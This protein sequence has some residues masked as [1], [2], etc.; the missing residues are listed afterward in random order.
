MA[1]IK[2]IAEKAG[3]SPATVSRVLNYDKSL[4][5]SDETRKKVFEIAEELDYKTVRERK[6]E[7]EVGKRIKVG[8]INWYSEKEELGDP[9]YLSI[10]LGAEKECYNKNVDIVK[11]FKQDDRYGINQ[12]DDLD[13]IIAIGKFSEDDIDTFLSYS[14]NI[15]FVDS[16]PNEKKFDSVVIDFKKAVLEVLKYLIKLGHNQI[17]YIGGREYVGNN[18]RLVEDEREETYISFMKEKGLFNPNNIYIGRFTAEDGY[19]LMKEALQKEE[20]PT[21]FFIAND[22]M[23]TG[24]IRALYEANLKVPD[25]IS[26]IGFNDNATSKFLVPPLSTVKVYTEFMGATAVNLLLE[27]INDNREI[28][29]KVI[30]PSELIIRES[31]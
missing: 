28:S 23:A 24:A 7:R 13:G 19:K 8:L 16:S 1:T 30:I 17:G 25:D 21:A 26:I 3:V 2:D 9:Y 5:V 10:R 4:S 12:F 20:V 31:C 18:K 29:K 14:K 27:R 15:V 6:K 11:I 22:T